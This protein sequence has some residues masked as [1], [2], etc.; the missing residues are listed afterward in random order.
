VYVCI[1]YVYQE[2]IRYLFHLVPSVLVSLC[3]WRAVGRQCGHMVQYVECADQLYLG[4]YSRLTWAGH[5]EWRQ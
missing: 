3:T 2:G 1:A 4:A 5:S